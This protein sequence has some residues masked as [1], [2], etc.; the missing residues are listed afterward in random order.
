[1]L[2][3]NSFPMMT[4]E[5]EALYLRHAGSYTASWYDEKVKSLVVAKY[6]SIECFIDKNCLHD[7]GATRELINTFLND[8]GAFYLYTANG[9]TSISKG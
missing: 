9:E 1:M 4:D 7:D 6:C 8:V 5:E 3:S 2:L